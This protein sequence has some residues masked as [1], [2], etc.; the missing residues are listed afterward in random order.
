M[1]A[2]PLDEFP[3]AETDPELVMVLVSLRQAVAD[4][5]EGL[6]HQALGVAELTKLRRLCQQAADSLDYHLAHRDDAPDT[7]L[8]DATA[9]FGAGLLDD[10]DQDEQD[11]RQDVDQTTA[12]ATATAPATG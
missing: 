12:G 4:A 5:P 9:R 6:A 1:A 11:D 7:A 3:R 8:A 10:D 2:T